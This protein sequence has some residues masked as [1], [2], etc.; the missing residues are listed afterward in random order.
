MSNYP[1]QWHDIIDKYH[2]RSSVLDDPT[3]P[4]EVDS[5]EDCHFVCDT[6]SIV[7]MK[8]VSFKS[9]KALARHCR[10][11]H[12][13]VSPILQYIDDSGI[14]PACNVNLHIRTKVIT[15][16][17]ETRRRGKGC[18][19]RC[20]D[21]I[22]NGSVPQIPAELFKQLDERDKARRRE[23]RNSGRTVA[24]KLM[25][26]P[27]V[28]VSSVSSNRKKNLLRDGAPVASSSSS[29][30]YRCSKRRTHGIDL[31][32]CPPKVPKTDFVPTTRVYVKTSPS[33]LEH[34]PAKRM[35]VKASS[36]LL[37]RR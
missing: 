5:K 22:L 13:V 16:A 32:P 18:D 2:T 37:Y 23:A 19:I 1:R 17:C 26:R 29:G 10:I 34:V 15:H 35:K 30:V 24:A 11:L 12:K 3:G 36:Y 25:A 27:A 31:N 7:G 6:C 20:L 9:A 33:S 21:V 14:C 8:V 4:N 28:R